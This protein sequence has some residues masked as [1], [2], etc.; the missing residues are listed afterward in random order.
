VRHDP[1]FIVHDDL[2]MLCKC[3]VAGA[4][5]SVI[6]EMLHRPAAMAPPGDPARA[7]L[8]ASRARVLMLRHLLQQSSSEAIDQMAQ[9]YA[10]WWPPQLDFAQ[11]LLATLAHACAMPAS[12]DQSQVDHEMLTRALRDGALRL[13]QVFFQAGLAD[14]PWLEARF[15][16]PEVA[17][18]LAP[19]A[20]QLPVRPFRA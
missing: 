8:F 6:P 12:P 10:Q 5:F 16:D 4:Q 19:L 15:M 20:N 17:R 18:F 1:E 2:H 11:R 3:A 9:L 7:A 13:L 14:K